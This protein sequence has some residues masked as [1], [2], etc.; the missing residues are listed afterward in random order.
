M[1]DNVF[2][3][4]LHIRDKKYYFQFL[5]NVINDFPKFKVKTQLLPFHGT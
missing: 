4:L 1:I 3:R 2:V 5:Y